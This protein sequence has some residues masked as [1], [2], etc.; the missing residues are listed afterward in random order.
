MQLDINPAWMSFDY[1]QQTGDP[2]A[3]TPSK[4]LPDQERPA[5]R[6]FEP[7]SRDFTAVYAR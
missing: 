7:T 2:A 4:L 3:P 6:Y 1:Y 5:D